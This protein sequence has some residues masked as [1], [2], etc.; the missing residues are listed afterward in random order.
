MQAPRGQAD[1]LSES[2]PLG[3]PRRQASIQNFFLRGGNVV[4]K[5]AQFDG[6]FINVI[7]DVCGF[8]IVVA[9]LADGADIYEIF[10]PLLDLEFR[11]SPAPHHAIADE[12]YRHVRVAEKT[13]R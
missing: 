1:S 7:N 13:N 5:S 9:R 4:I 2:Q 3:Q 11:V 10:F 6:A 12:S 8:R